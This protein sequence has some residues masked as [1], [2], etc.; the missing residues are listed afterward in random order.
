MRTHNGKEDLF[1][2]KGEYIDSDKQKIT[3]LL[4]ILPS[5]SKN[6]SDIENIVDVDPITHEVIIAQFKK[7]SEELKEQRFG[8]HN[9]FDQTCKNSF[10][11]DQL[12]DPS[13][14]NS[15]FNLFWEGYN[16][17][18]ITYGEIG[19]GKT[20]TLYGQEADEPDSYALII[21]NLM[22]LIDQDRR[23]FTIGVS[24]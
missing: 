21:S 4:R 7:S 18:L 16:A 24:I 8:I 23:E 9:V 12:F 6:S 20:F 22:S 11:R 19:S 14:Q 13:K 1:D 17:G 3:G 15:I 10:I 2:P 5:K